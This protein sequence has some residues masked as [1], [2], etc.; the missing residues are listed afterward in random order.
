MTRAPDQSLT[1]SDSFSGSESDSEVNWRLL[2]Q[3]I[4]KGVL[5]VVGTLSC[6]S[7]SFSDR[8]TDSEVILA[9]LLVL[10]DCTLKFATMSVGSGPSSGDGVMTVMRTQHQLVL[11]SLL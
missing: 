1:L 5:T 7:D 6:R 10:P 11:G 4:D 9:P 2:P 3:G 8:D